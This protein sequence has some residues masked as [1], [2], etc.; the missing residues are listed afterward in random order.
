[1]SKYNAMI[2]ELK[3]FYDNNDYLLHA[4]GI[5][6]NNPDMA[7]ID[8]EGYKP[9]KKNSL[10]EE[11]AQY[12]KAINDGNFNEYIELKKEAIQVL[13]NNKGWL[14]GNTLK[15]INMYGCIVSGDRNYCTIYP[16]CEDDSGIIPSVNVSINRGGLC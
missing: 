11:A 8:I 1:M 9:L 10:K 5:A 13:K 2:T 3:T 7:I 4:A 16:K 14:E 15:L 12:K 6:L